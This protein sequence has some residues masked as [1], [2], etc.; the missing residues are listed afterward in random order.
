MRKL[1]IRLNNWV[2]RRRRVRVAPENLLLLIPHCLQRSACPRNVAHDVNQ[3]ARCGQCA[4][5][6]ILSL[7]DRLGVKC[8]LASGG[9]QAVTCAHDPS[10]RMIVAVACEKELVDG[11]VASFPKPVLAVP[12]LRP[13]GP[14]K[15]T[16]VDVAALEAALREVLIPADGQDKP[17]QF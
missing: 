11:I 12:N 13:H 16:R 6:E 1:I 2:T 5:A 4:I 8:S 3:C 17:T 9:R 14:C 10:I 7:R 15:D